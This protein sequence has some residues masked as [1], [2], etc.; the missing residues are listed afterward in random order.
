MI[1]QTAKAEFV[2]IPW[3]EV[4]SPASADRCTN[5]RRRYRKAAGGA[6]VEIA[7]TDNVSHSTISRLAEVIC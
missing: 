3:D 1:S 2:L 5:G 6:L 4:R 7:R